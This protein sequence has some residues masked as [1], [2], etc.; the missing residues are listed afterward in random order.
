MIE[1]KNIRLRHIQEKDLEEFFLRQLSFHMK[2]GYIFGA[3][4]SEYQFKNKFFK[5][6]FWDNNEG[7]MLIINDKNIMIGMIRFCKLNFF[8]ALEIG[9]IIFEEEKL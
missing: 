7:I 3:I 5:T 8:E 2:P 4:E 6:G 9:Y 1:G